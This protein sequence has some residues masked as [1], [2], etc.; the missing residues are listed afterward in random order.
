MRRRGRGTRRPIVEGERIEVGFCL[1]QHDLARG[2]FRVGLGDK[3][4]DGGVGERDARDERDRGQERLG[5]S[6]G[7]RMF[8]P[9]RSER[10]RERA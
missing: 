9:G 8:V 2:A 10:W 4:T 1:L 7:G 3:G 5:F 6:G